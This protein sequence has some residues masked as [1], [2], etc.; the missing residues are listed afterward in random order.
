MEKNK[1]NI[2]DIGQLISEMLQFEKWISKVLYPEENLR[3][4]EYI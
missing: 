4:S 2:T 3:Y 1:H